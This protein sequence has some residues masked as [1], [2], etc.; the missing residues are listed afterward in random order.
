M[1]ILCIAIIDIF[2]QYG[3]NKI[4]FSPFMRGYTILTGRVFP[5]GTN[6]CGGALLLVLMLCLS[7]FAG[8]LAEN[9]DAAATGETSKS[10]SAT[11]LDSNYETTVTL[12]FPSAQ[13]SL[14]SDVVFVL[15]KSTSTTV[16]QAALGMLS[17]L[18][19]Q[20]KDTDAEINVAV[21][22]FNKKATTFG[23]Y[24]LSTQYTE[25]QSA[26]EY[27]I[28][29]GTNS[30][31]G[32]LAAQ[33]LLENDTNVANDRKHLIFV[34]DGLTYIFGEEATSVAWNY[35]HADT[36]VP[37]IWKDPSVWG[38]KYGSQNPPADGWGNWLRSTE[39]LVTKQGATYDWAYDDTANAGTL[40]DASKYTEYANSVDKALYLTAKTYKECEEAGYH[41]Y[42]VNT[43]ANTA[44]P[45]GASFMNYLKTGETLSGDDLNA[46]IN[47]ISYETEE[48]GEKK[49]YLNEDYVKTL[50]VPVEEEIVYLL[51]Y[52]STVIDYIGDDFDLV[53]DSFVLKVGDTEY[54]LTKFSYVGEGNVPIGT[55]FAACDKD[56]KY[57]WLY[58]ISYFPSANETFTPDGEGIVLTIYTDVTNFQRVELSYKLKL[59]NPKT[60]AGT[61]GQYDQYGENGYD[62]LHTNNSAVLHPMDSHENRGED[63]SFNKPTVSYTVYAPT[64]T[65]PPS[66]DI[67][68]PQTGDSTPLVLL[69]ALMVLSAAGVAVILKRQRAHR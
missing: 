8:A 10:K 55:I 16:E 23:W 7:L 5:C 13:V 9:A 6:V 59:T 24:K 39:S 47:E 62:A 21:V 26:I 49:R 20:I 14:D 57:N 22:I 40:T 30:H 31:A 28:S 69:A 38:L 68:V 1:T 2:A 44:Y 60:T 52:E 67:D 43:Y 64:E 25:I 34:S 33:K 45:W 37:K 19:K 46:L 41:C 51:G 17:N 32:L 48:N 12:S 3:Y 11:N 4:D 53:E 27:T 42:A 56:D 36:T 63:E 54:P 61:Y 18:K 35:L 50:F 65:T 29:S 66:G 58:Q 15:D